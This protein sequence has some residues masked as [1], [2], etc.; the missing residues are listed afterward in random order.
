MKYYRARMQEEWKPLKDYEGLYE[1]SNKGRVLRLGRIITDSL[2]RKRP[3][4]DLLLKPQINIENGYVYVHLGKGDKRKLV[5]LHRLVAKN[6]IPKVSG[7]T[8]VN[9]IDGNKENNR[10]ENLEWVTAQ[11]NTLHAY[12]NGLLRNYGER[13]GW[14]KLTNKEAKEIKD[15]YFND[16]YNQ[17]E[18]AELYEVSQGTISH[19]VRGITYVKPSKRE[20][21]L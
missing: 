15:L 21:I 7:K 10:V 11:E 16:F 12:E 20:V 8:Y 14:S 17:D 2:G 13:N 18:L 1:I 4:K 6:F 9:H 19:L 3:I 5:S